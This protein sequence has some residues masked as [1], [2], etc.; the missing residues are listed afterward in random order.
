MNHFF[1]DL[2]TEINYIMEK[3]Y[4]RNRNLWCET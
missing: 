3:I 2:F 4:V 1:V